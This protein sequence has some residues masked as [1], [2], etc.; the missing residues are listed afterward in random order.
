MRSS[1]DRTPPPEVLDKAPGKIP[2]RQLRTLK[3]Q[4]E[5]IVCVG[6]PDVSVPLPAM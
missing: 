4:S 6:A 2:R 1:F 5:P 3:T